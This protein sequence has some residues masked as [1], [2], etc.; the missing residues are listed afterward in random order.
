M[1]KNELITRLQA[2]LLG[3]KSA[4]MTDSWLKD[5][6]DVYNFDSRVWLQVHELLVAAGVSQ[7]VEKEVK[8]TAHR[9]REVPSIGDMDASAQSVR[10]VWDDA[11][12]EVSEEATVPTH[13]GIGDPRAAVYRK[14]P[15]SEGKIDN[16]KLICRDP[17]L[18]TRRLQYLDRST[19]LLE[20]AHKNCG[21]WQKEIYERSTIM[22][23]Q[24]IVACSAQDLP[25]SSINAEDLV[26][27]LESYE[28]ANRSV[29]KRGFVTSTMGWHGSDTDP[30][31][32]GF[33]CGHRQ[34]GGNGKSIEVFY[35][36]GG[37]DRSIREIS[38]RGT[39]QGWCDAIAPLDQFPMVRVAIY[40]SLC[41]PLIAVLRAPNVIVEWCGETTKGKSTA[42]IFANT[43]WKSAEDRLPTWNTTITGLE[44]KAQVLNDF[45]MIIDDT[46]EIPE[47]KRAD[48]LTAAVYMLESGHSRTRSNKSLTQAASK[49]WRTI[50]LSTGEYTLSDYAGTGGAAARVL[51]FWGAPL[52]EYSDEK[53]KLLATVFDKLRDNYGV[54]GPALIEWLCANREQ[55]DE[56]RR[57]YQEC[58]AVVRQLSHTAPGVRLA[59]AIALLE[60]AS[61]L[62]HKIFNLPWAH[63][64]L[65]ADRSLIASLEDA[66]G[67]S[68]NNSNKAKKAWEDVL[69]FAESQPSRWC[70][71]GNVLK[72]GA[73]GYGGYLGWRRIADPEVGDKF[74]L[75]CQVL[76]WFPHHLKKAL[77]D[78]GYPADAI[79][80][81]WRDKGVLCAEKGRLTTKP[82]C[83]GTQNG[84]R[85]CVVKMTGTI[86]NDVGE[87]DGAWNH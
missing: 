86:W 61:R 57:Q 59:P 29:I 67:E 18:I 37:E 19:V 3:D 64:S 27:Y 69:G 85:M 49:Q 14:L 58:T 53:A 36:D 30:T 8:K 5:L 28:H 38:S 2:A 26:H 79:M 55:W 75:G 9:L 82:R 39:I 6:A 56:L 1:A 17:I 23:K 24:K 50:V 44:A 45:P 34:I 42:L 60:I 87:D 84:P 66:I 43:V 41:S 72:S 70:V 81:T 40:A 46:A 63:K 15:S 22:S 4:V 35:G 77:Q 52:G 16:R 7:L 10:S 20:I 54:A 13:Y 83:D 48:L 21:A 11:P 25:V 51:T 73:D 68:E 80:R 12:E 47:H 78:L 62:A 76:A 74:A 65:I 31:A 33:L 32:H 71:W